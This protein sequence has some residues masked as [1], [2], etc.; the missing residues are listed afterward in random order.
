MR[1]QNKRL[2]Q[3]L[4]ML[5]QAADNAIVRELEVRSR[6]HKESQSEAASL[7]KSIFFFSN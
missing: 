5:A 7:L 1:E 6:K 2:K 3:E 4:K